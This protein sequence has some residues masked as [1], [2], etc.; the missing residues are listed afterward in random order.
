MAFFARTTICY[1]LDE[2]EDNWIADQHELQ[3][4]AMTKFTLERDCLKSPVVIAVDQIRERFLDRARDGS[5]E[6]SEVRVILTKL[7]SHIDAETQ[8][9]TFQ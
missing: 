4:W 6:A 2:V 3:Q 1:Y 5:Y 8:D 7:N 9:V